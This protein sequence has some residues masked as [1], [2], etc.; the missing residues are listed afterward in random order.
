M[1]ALWSDETTTLRTA[2]ENFTL[3]EGA[4]TGSYP[5]LGDTLISEKV[6]A[7]LPKGM[8]LHWTLPAAL[9]HG[10]TVY[11][12]T[13][14]VCHELL[15]HGVPPQLV[16]SLQAAAKDTEYDHSGMQG[17]LSSLAAQTVAPL[18]PDQWNAAVQNMGKA[19]EQSA[20]AWDALLLQIYASLILKTAAHMKLPR[21]PNRWLVL[22]SGGTK[23]EPSWVV[24][25]DRLTAA[26]AVPTGTLAGPCTM[27]VSISDDGTPPSTGWQYLGLTQPAIGWV[28]DASAA[29]LEPFT[30]AG[31]GLPEFAAFYPSCQ[32]VFGLHDASALPDTDY[33]YTVIGWFSADDP[34][35]SGSGVKALNVLKCSASAAVVTDKDDGDT[36][37]EKGVSVAVGNSTGQALAAALAAEMALKLTRNDLPDYDTQLK[38]QQTKI[39]KLL[40]A[41]QAGALRHYDEPD[42][43]A[44]MEQALH[45]QG[46]RP[47]HGGTTWSLVPQAGAAAGLSAELPLQTA[48]RAAAAAKPGDVIPPATTVLPASVADLLNALNLAQRRYD[49]ALELLLTQRE[50]LF[51][52]WHRSL[53]LNSAHVDFLGRMS[54]D[55]TASAGMIKGAD[56]LLEVKAAAMAQAS[57]LLLHEGCFCSDGAVIPA[58]W[59]LYQ[60]HAAL[61]TSIQGMPLT[62]SAHP[63]PRFWQPHDPVVLFH[64]DQG[65]NLLTATP[66]Q[67]LTQDEQGNLICSQAPAAVLAVP[68]WSATFQGLI[69]GLDASLPVHVVTKSSWR[70]LLLEWSADFLPCKGSGELKM[71]AEGTVTP[72]TYLD[73]FLQDNYKTDENGIDLQIVDDQK[74]ASTDDEHATYVGRVLLSSRAMSSMKDRILSLLGTQKPVAGKDIVFPGTIGKNKDMCQWLN[75]AANSNAQTLS[76]ALDGFHDHLLMRQRI[77]QFA[78][79]DPKAAQSSSPAYATQGYESAVTWNPVTQ[80]YFPAIGR[81]YAHS[82]VQDD[83]YHPIRAGVCEISALTLVD[84]FGQSRRWKMESG[85]SVAVTRTLPPYQPESEPGSV[86]AAFHLPPRFTQPSRL[87]FRWMAADG[88]GT[89]ANAHPATTPV[90]GWLML[91]RVDESILFFSAEGTLLGWV[92]SGQN[93]VKMP[94]AADLSGAM[95]ALMTEFTSKNGTDYDDAIATALLTIEPH[96]HRQHTAASVLVSRPLAVCA[97]SLRLELKGMPAPHQGFACVA[98]AQT[99]AG[100]PAALDASSYFLQRQTCDFEKVQVPVRLGDVSMEDD[101]LVAWWPLDAKGTPEGTWNLVDPSQQTGAEAVLPLTPAPNLL[102]SVTSLSTSTATQ[103]LLL[104]DPRACV[105]A[106]SGILPVKSI[107]L[108]PELYTEALKKMELIFNASPV[109]TPAPTPLITPA[110]V[111]PPPVEPWIMPVPAE[112]S[113]TWSWLPDLQPATAPQPLTGKVD[114]RAHLPPQPAVLRRGWLQAKLQE[115]KGGV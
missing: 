93:W 85:R 52:D 18:T 108:P 103:V 54:A 53:M 76:Q 3:L 67:T 23:G 98:Q 15:A 69:S 29:R 19:G 33:T 28:E 65:Q 64:D 83:L 45:Q 90:L 105:H 25:S 48:A 97:A 87:L 36:L 66:A 72:T 46:F 95:N 20:L 107:T 14:E 35:G 80:S 24:E 81:S 16:A 112:L 26:G 59:A 94:G 115:K 39:E 89:E 86:P 82:P 37:G 27:Q 78:P 60:A 49:Q 2:L 79:Y 43:D 96:S 61:L 40:D 7:E 9:T 1:D 104:L 32:G 44:L 99:T 34:V 63:A 58:A 62:L 101:G 51:A 92:D 4:V 5:W 74:I 6:G 106:S 75:L 114:D 70:P 50:Q 110:P 13:D 111:P 57:S 17:V 22:R 8:H 84:R 10:H 41:A 91:N 100:Y 47:S 68:G 55:N 71:D 109:L 38:D 21:V 113:S 102:D 73:T 30:A 88:S 31:S 11:Q 77:R 42:G 56:D 12:I